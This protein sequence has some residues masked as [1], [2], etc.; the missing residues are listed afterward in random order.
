[1]GR[2]PAVP[3]WEDLRWSADLRIG[4]IRAESRS[5]RS[6]KLRAALRVHFP[7]HSVRKH[8]VELHEVEH[9]PHR[10]WRIEDADADGAVGSAGFFAQRHQRAESGAVDETG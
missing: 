7:I 9:P 2:R 4:A 3:R 5:Q 10:G 8:P 6:K 1:M